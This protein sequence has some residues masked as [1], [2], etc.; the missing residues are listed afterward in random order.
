VTLAATSTIDE[1]FVTGASG[2]FR[3]EVRLTVEHE[4]RRYLIGIAS[5]GY[6]I[7]DY[8]GAATD[9]RRLRASVGLLYYL[10]RSLA[11]R[12]ELRHERLF[13]NVPGQDYTANIALVGLRLQ[14]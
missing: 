2:L 4:F 6:A 9:D 8:I 3:H 7:E 14:R 12:G 10:N 5:I 13:S 11:A 1:T